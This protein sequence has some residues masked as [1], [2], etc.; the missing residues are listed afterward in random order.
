MQKRDRFI[1]FSS[2]QTLRFTG[3]TSRWVAFLQRDMHFQ[4][5]P[6]SVVDRVFST[7][8]PGEKQKMESFDYTLCLP[9]VPGFSENLK[10][11]LQKQ[12]IWVAFRKGQTLESLLCRLKFRELITKYKNKTCNFT[13]IG[14]T[15]QYQECKDRGQRNAIKSGNPNNSFFD[16]LQ[17]NPSHEI[18][19]E[20]VSYLD[21]EKKHGQAND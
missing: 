8:K 20:K 16:H 18:D 17:K 14:E 3:R 6:S 19:W 5:F 15:S 2:S 13:C 9:F 12:G 11:E 10:R 21:K 1:N 4:W 7:Y